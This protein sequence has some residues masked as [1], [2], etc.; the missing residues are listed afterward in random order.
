MAV[1]GDLTDKIAVMKGYREYVPEHNVPYDKEE[2][3]TEEQE[4]TESGFFPY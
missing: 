4:R 3:P 1:I 2:I